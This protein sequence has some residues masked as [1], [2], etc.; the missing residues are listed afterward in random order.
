MSSVR[1][2]DAALLLGAAFADTSDTDAAH[3]PPP[4]QG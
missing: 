3:A 1:L 2:E 4:S